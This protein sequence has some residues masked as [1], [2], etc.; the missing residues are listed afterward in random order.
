MKSYIKKP[1]SMTTDFVQIVLDSEE[2]CSYLEENSV[3]ELVRK[4]LVQDYRELKSLNSLVAIVTS[5]VMCAV[6][7]KLR[8]SVSEGTCL[9]MRYKESLIQDLEDNFPKFPETSVY[10]G[11]S[12]QK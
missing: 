3:S 11:E 8:S 6:A 5:H 10:C 1:L 7:A 12:T 2:L 9:G 4:V